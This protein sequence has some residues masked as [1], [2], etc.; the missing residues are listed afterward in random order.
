MKQYYFGHEEDKH[1][2]CNRFRIHFGKTVD[3]YAKQY[4]IPKQLLSGIIANEMLDWKFPD[5]TPLDGIRGGEVGYA[6]ITIKTASCLYNY[7]F[8]ENRSICLTKF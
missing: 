1:L 6:Q 3:K 2:R 7:C 4:N 8:V 5:G